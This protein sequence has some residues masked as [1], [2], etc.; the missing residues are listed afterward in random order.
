M[1][2]K[3]FREMLMMDYATKNQNTG[4]LGDPNNVSSG[5]LE[6]T[7]G[8]FSNLGNINPNILLGANIVGQGVR[9]NDPFSSFLPAVQ[10]T[11]KIQSQFMQMEEMKRKMEEN[12]KARALAEKQRNF[13]EDLPEDHPFKKLAEAFPGKAAT[14]IIE[15]E[16]KNIDQTAKNKKDKAD[17]IAELLKNIQDQENKL[18]TSYQ[19]NSV[20]KEFDAATTSITKLLKGLEKDDGVGDVA[21]IFTFMKTLDPSS[22]V[23]EGEFAVA[24]NSSGVY[25]K[26]WN[27]YNKV[28]KGDR[29]TE[30]QRE[31]FKQ[32]GISLYAQ[33][34]QA[35]DNLRYNFTQI[36]NNQGLNIDNIFVDS[37]IRPK[38]ENVQTTTAPG[39]ESE[40]KT[41]RVPPGAVLV[42][43]Q[44]GKY[45][46]RV[47]GRK[48]FL[49]TDGFK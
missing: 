49:V 21:S 33:N 41:Q 48:E 30:A 35:I 18:F 46:F 29:L 40:F 17:K 34:Q 20:V 25:R 42:D 10:E 5:L 15:M 13:F 14:G 11:G 1:F 31:S 38:F 7:G 2:D 44:D 24:E 12:K 16:L 19:S 32:L 45:Y 9:G 26:F 23:R 8:F 36:A 3:R 37:D 28:L 4:V 47:P 22:V 27:L 6:N 39:Q 43:Y